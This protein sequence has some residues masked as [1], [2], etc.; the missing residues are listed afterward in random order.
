MVSI[1]I[2]PVS[3]RHPTHF[4]TFRH[5]H[6]YHQL[7]NNFIRSDDFPN[8]VTEAAL[9]LAGAQVILCTLSM[10]S[11]P[12]LRASGIASL[13]EIQTIIVDE[14]SQIEVGDYIPLLQACH[15]IK[16]MV[17]VGDNKQCEFSSLLVS[18][19]AFLLIYCKSGSLWPG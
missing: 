14:A 9:A 8:S 3:P 6:L 10:L 17:F 12:G 18:A 19:L 11:H 4:F 1:F 15:G 13:V 5:E 7:E 16:K 2:P